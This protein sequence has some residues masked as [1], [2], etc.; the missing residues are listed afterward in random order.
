VLKALGGIVFIV[1]HR[2]LIVTFSAARDACISVVECCCLADS[3]YECSSR[4]L[5]DWVLYRYGGR[6]QGNWVVNIMRSYISADLL[7]ILCRSNA[8]NDLA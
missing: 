1:G 7:C 4:I 6:V 3:L 5:D 8:L 2:R